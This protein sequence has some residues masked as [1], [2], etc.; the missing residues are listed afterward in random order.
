MEFLFKVHKILTC[1]SDIIS[2]ELPDELPPFRDIQYDINFDLGF[3]LS[4][5]S[6]YRIK[7]IVLAELR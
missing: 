1:F 4:N 3:S 7:P 2:D 5:L 6:H